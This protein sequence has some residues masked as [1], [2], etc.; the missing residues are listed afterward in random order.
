MET[1]LIPPILVKRWQT[2][3]ALLEWGGTPHGLIK[4]NANYI[5]LI[6]G[7]KAGSIYV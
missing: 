6:P 4:K 5:I 3:C 7:K 1:Y 2:L